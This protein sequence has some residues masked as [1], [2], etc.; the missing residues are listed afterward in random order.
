[1]EWIQSE[2]RQYEK[3]LR[4]L[5]L[6][7]EWIKVIGFFTALKAKGFDATG[8][9]PFPDSREEILRILKKVT[10]DITEDWLYVSVRWSGT[11]DNKQVIYQRALWCRDTKIGY[12][13]KRG[14]P[15]TDWKS[16]STSWLSGTKIDWD[17]GQYED[18]NGKERLRTIF[19][20]ILISFDWNCPTQ[21]ANMIVHVHYLQGFTDLSGTTLHRRP[22]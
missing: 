22:T 3:E 15:K 9:S 7:P 1:M 13:R 14:T 4:K 5:V 17:V 2:I 21:T 19:R 12:T 16:R 10:I 6:P 18:F 20:D 8:I 11:E